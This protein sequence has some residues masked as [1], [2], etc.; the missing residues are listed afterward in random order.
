M[1]QSS[2]IKQLLISLL[3]AAT[4]HATLTT[5][6]RGAGSNNSANTSFDISPTSNMTAGS[7]GVLV[8]A[9]DNANG[10][11]G[12]LSITS[13][14][15]SAGNVWYRRAYGFGGSANVNTEG[16]FFT[17][18]LTNGLT[19]S[20]T[21]TVTTLATTTAKAWTL[22]EIGCDSGNTV[23]FCSSNWTGS[24]ATGAPT[25]TSFEVHVG[26]IVIGGGSAE[27]ADTWTGDSDTTNGSWSTKQS[28]A[29]GTGST[30]CSVI[31][32]VKI[33]TTAYS[34]QTYNPTL[35]SADVRVGWLVVTESDPKARSAS[36]GTTTEAATTIS[37]SF[38]LASG[39]I[40]VLVIAADNSISGG[41]TQNLPASISD[42]Q[43]NTW[44]LRQTGIYDPGAAN[45]GVEI[46]I[47]TSVLT[48]GLTPTDTLTCTYQTT[49]VPVK[50]WGIWEFAPTGGGVMSYVTG[51]VGSGANTATPSVTTG[52]ITSGDYVI[53]LCGAETSND[54][55][56]DTGSTN[57][58]WKTQ[59][60]FGRATLSGGMAFT[61]QWKKT[62][63]TATQVYAPTL[64]AADTMIGWISINDSSTSAASTADFFFIY[65]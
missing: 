52:S 13:I 23:L 58:A 56:G 14:T 16:V 37:V 20:G 9:L 28:T 11:S 27:S 18:R 6:D 15:D 53:G 55:A 35:T 41:G 22:T 39:S 46:G 49:N 61:T 19:T 10:S 38:P 4:A 29:A 17:S 65:P 7:Y 25:I 24:S 43:S 1:G 50:S 51:A 33:Q 64:G 47:Y 12:D 44:T 32:Q 2:S 45:A 42:T 3:F 48:T 62:T 21:I 8:L 54:F 40:G 5:T 30:G 26:D 63:A 59:L 57:G 31:S 34:S 60:T 36:G